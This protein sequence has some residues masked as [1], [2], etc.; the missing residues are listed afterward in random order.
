MV[1]KL[2]KAIGYIPPRGNKAARLTSLSECIRNGEECAK[3]FGAMQKETEARMAGRK[4]FSGYEGMPYSGTIRCLQVTVQS[5]KVLHQ[6]ME[7]IEEG[8]AE[9][10]LPHTLLSESYIEH[11]FENVTKSGQGH[12]LTMDEYI[13]AK[14]RVTL[15]FQLKMC[16][17]P[18]WQHSREKLQDKGYQELVSNDNALPIRDLKEIFRFS[19]KQNTFET[20]QTLSEVDE[21]LLQK[22]YLLAKSVPRQ[23]NR[24]KWR[25]RSGHQPN[26]LAEK[27]ISG[28]LYKNDLVFCQSV[29]S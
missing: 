20:P 25:E 3:L 29:I 16:Q 9:K 11:S 18:F 23:S 8:S 17:M 14:R 5:W 4:S 7:K 13:I 2:Y 1:C 12:N 10:I 28:V 26:M 24:A 19:E 22:A 21:H 6:R 15:N 27:V